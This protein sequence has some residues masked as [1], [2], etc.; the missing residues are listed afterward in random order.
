MISRRL[1]LISKSAQRNVYDSL[2]MALRRRF[3]ACI[4]RT[5]F[6]RPTINNCHSTRP[7]LTIARPHSTGTSYFVMD[8]QTKLEIIDEIKNHQKLIPAK[9]PNFMTALNAFFPGSCLMSEFFFL[10]N[11]MTTN[12]GFND[13][14]TMGMAALCRDE[15]TEGCMQQIVKY[16]GKTFNCSS[17]A[18]F[19]TIGNTGLGAATAHAP[20]DDKDG[21]RRF[22]FVAMPHIAISED[23]KVGACKREGIEQESNA[24]GALDAIVGELQSGSVRI[25]LDM[26]DVEQSLVRQRLLAEL[27]YG[28]KPMLNELTRTAAEIIAQDVDELLTRNLDVRTFEYVVV[29]GIQIHGPEDIDWVFP[30]KMWHV[31]NHYVGGRTHLTLTDIDSFMAAENK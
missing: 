12:L 11:D 2:Q 15:I 6:I 9:Y 8:Q 5:R 4:T 28:E 16:W 10:A 30:G 24:C 25:R 14:N 3:S 23:G 13:E 19:I 20:I 27:P 17:L 7:T 18:G 1:R 21:K 26:D 31:S 29:T 22:V